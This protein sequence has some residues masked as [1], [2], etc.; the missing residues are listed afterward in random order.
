MQERVNENPCSLQEKS[1]TKGKFAKILV[2]ALLF[3]ACP[4]DDIVMLA[5]VVSPLAGQTQTNITPILELFWVSGKCEKMK[6]KN[7]EILP[8]QKCDDF[9]EICLSN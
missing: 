5:A 3:I 9:E 6:I 7:P 2:A 1:T 8:V 4:G